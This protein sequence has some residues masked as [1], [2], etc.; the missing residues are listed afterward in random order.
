M[1]NGKFF[2]FERNRFYCGKLLTSSD[3]KEEQNY[4]NNKRRFLNKVLFGAG[5]VNG[6]KTYSVDDTTLM[7]ESG[8]AIDSQGREIVLEK[9]LVK[10]LSTV[11][12][13]NDVRGTK[14]DLCVEYDETEIN[15]LYSLSKNDAGKEYEYNRVLEGVRFFV[16]NTEEAQKLESADEQFVSSNILFEDEHFRLNLKVPKFA[17][18]DYD[19]NL[20]ACLEKISS[21]D[22]SF[23][24]EWMVHVPGFANEQ[25]DNRLNFKFKE[26]KLE[27]SRKI[28]LAQAIRLEGVLASNKTT[29]VVKEGAAKFAS[30]KASSSLKENVFMTVEIR[31]D[32]PIDIVKEQVANLPMETVIT[33]I[34]HP[35]CIAKIEI[36]KVDAK[37]Y[38]INKVTRPDVHSGIYVPVQQYAIEKLLEY[39]KDGQKTKAQ[40]VPDEKK[41]TE[42]SGHSALISAFNSTISCG[43]VDVPIGQNVKS[44]KVIY[45][46]EVMHG[47]GTGDVFVEVGVEYILRGKNSGVSRK[48]VYGDDSIFK[49]SLPG[50]MSAKKAVKVFCDKGTFMVGVRF[51]EQVNISAMR[52]KWFAFK[53]P[54]FTGVIE[55]EQDK[56]KSIF[57]KKDALV[58]A[59]NEMICVDVGFKNMTVTTLKYEVVDKDGGTID[60]SG[61]YNAPNKEGVYEVKVSCVN[62]PDVYTYAYIIVV[63]KDV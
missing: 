6:F 38:V 34:G 3:F 25:G 32:E 4:F 50:A 13:F 45:S 18:R 5:V 48:V 63:K 27:C 61:M 44:G 39:Y 43:S 33:D 21:A 47:L 23:S 19:L 55:Q 12:G 57:V 37:T 15:P 9:S 35:I 42:S 24:G 49:D 29:F 52:L 31:N 58:V 20:V 46:D 7:V 30:G 59:P 62:S 36:V 40:E 51:E 54:E 1:L 53:T 26:V 41:T 10:K 16:R 60:A 11:D 17:C 2:P 28:T 22:I 14:L 56:E 8:V